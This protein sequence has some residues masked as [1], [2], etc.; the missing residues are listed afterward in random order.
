MRLT[1]FFTF[2]IAIHIS[3]CCSK[4]PK[5]IPKGFSFEIIDDIDSY[6][7]INGS[8]TRKAIND[9]FLD[10][11]VVYTLSQKD[12]EEIYKV[13]IENDVLS[14]PKYFECASNAQFMIPSF[15][16]TLKVQI[17]GI[18]Q[19][20]K[21]DTSCFP[22]K[23]AGAANRF[24]NIVKYIRAKLHSQKIIQKLPKTKMRLM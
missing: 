5:E 14:I 13:L 18:K 3:I 6:N 15:N 19:E 12:K 7:S 4:Y 10:T 22:K 23:D 11:I 8:F 9:K 16:T 17:N 2:L 24:D 1:H 21:F 20:I